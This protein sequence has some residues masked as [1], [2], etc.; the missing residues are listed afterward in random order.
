MTR[1]GTEAGRATCR[2]AR[3]LLADDTP[4]IRNLIGMLLA[5]R[6][7]EVVAVENGAMAL[8]KALSAHRCGPAFDAVLMDMQMPVMDGYEATRRLRQQGYSGRI[9]ALTAHAMTGDRDKCL[10]AGCDDYLP[11]PIDPDRLADAVAASVR[12][13]RAAK[14]PDCRL[15]QNA[16]PAAD[17]GPLRSQYADRPAI[18]RLLGEFVGRLDER[19]QAMEMALA[20]SQTDELRRLAHQLKGAAGSYGYPGLSAAAKILEDEARQGRLGP[21][22][23]ALRRVVSLCRAA[24]MGWVIGPAGTAVEPAQRHESGLPCREPAC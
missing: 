15:P 2:G 4:D 6:G 3:I 14:A 1:L 7:A 18:A 12:A 13:G 8:E 5:G 19:V 21:A 23:D 17:E 11:K 16:L 24:E 22:G 20:A 9:I 10:E